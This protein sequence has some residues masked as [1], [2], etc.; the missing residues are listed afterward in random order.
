MLYRP[1]FFK[2]SRL[3]R[4]ESSRDWQVAKGNAIVVAL[5][6]EATAEHVL[7]HAVQLA[8][9]WE[10]PLHLV[11]VVIPEYYWE[12]GEAAL[13]ANSEWLSGRRQAETYLESVAEAITIANDIPVTAD[14]VSNISI[15]RGLSALS[16]DVGRLL[17]VAKPPRT[18]LSQVYFGST[19]NSL[20][21]KLSVPLLIVPNQ[22]SE[23]V[24]ETT[25]YQQILVGI[26]HGDVSESILNAAMAF[27]TDAVTYRLLHVFSPRAQ[28]T[29]ARTARFFPTNLRQEAMARMHRAEAWLRRQKVA[30]TSLLLDD[31]RHSPAQAV[32]EQGN[33]LAADLIVLGTRRRFLPW[34]LRRGVPEYIVRHT[35]RPVLLVPSD[36]NVPVLMRGNHVDIHSN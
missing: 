9:R 36:S 24:S 13:F 22:S 35:T 2:R 23:E 34:W 3:V 11:Q 14:V 25:D 31:W 26:G 28:M 19:S 33:S 29:M 15:E 21:G 7:R 32:L 27:A 10:S 20:V 16:A 5:N 1:R 18:G 8:Q 6:G 17:I 30:A 4:S 12:R